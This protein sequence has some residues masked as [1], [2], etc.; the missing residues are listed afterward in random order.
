MAIAYITTTKKIIGSTTCIRHTSQHYILEPS[1]ILTL[2]FY[3]K[4]QNKHMKD[5]ES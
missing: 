5:Y 1:Q 2:I 4:N 3:N